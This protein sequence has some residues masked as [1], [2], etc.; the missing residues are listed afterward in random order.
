MSNAISSTIHTKKISPAR[1]GY[2]F[3]VATLLFFLFL[4]VTS[5]AARYY[6]I[7]L[8][9]FKLSD[10]NYLDSENIVKQWSSPVGSNDIQIK[11]R[12]AQQQLY[13]LD[14]YAQSETLNSI[15][16]TLSDSSRYNILYSG[17][18]TTVFE[19]GETKKFQLQN[20]VIFNRLGQTIKNEDAISS[21]L[22]AKSHQISGELTATLNYYLDINLKIQYLR[23][24]FSLTQ[25]FLPPEKMTT[26]DFVP[27]DIFEMDQN[28]R[29]SSNKLWYVDGAVIGALLEFI[30]LE[31]EQ[32]IAS[33]KDVTAANTIK[34][35]L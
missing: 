1:W 10:S 7:N 12:Q 18:W 13:P 3:I 6:Q 22:D 23:Q 34:E 17:A 25:D 20:S 5:F 11:P 24:N 2:L 31:E 8:M 29:T 16:Q 30:P 14:T 27:F 26:L 9:V 35:Q 4:P 32:V 33:N 19:Q 15:S 21:A 28:V